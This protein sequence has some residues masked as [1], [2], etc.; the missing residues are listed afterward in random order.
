ML[1]AY[2][3]FNMHAGVSET[4]RAPFAFS[5]DELGMATGLPCKI[6]NPPF[7]VTLQTLERSIVF[8]FV[9]F[10]FSTLYVRGFQL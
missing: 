9:F 4:L 8:V 5:Y 3:I 7:V 6:L 1:R 10:F 2:R